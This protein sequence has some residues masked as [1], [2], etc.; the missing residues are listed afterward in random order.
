MGLGQTR[1]R[2]THDHER[3][4][5]RTLRTRLDPAAGTELFRELAAGLGL[6]ELREHVW[7]E[8]P[9]RPAVLV[10]AG[11]TVGPGVYLALWER[12]VGSE[13]DLVAASWAYADLP[14]ALAQ[15]W[16]ERDVSVA[17]QG[18]V[19]W[20]EELNL[21]PNRRRLSERAE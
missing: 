4:P 21:L 9:D 12:E 13:V 15:R 6:T 7:P 20:I 17:G 5:G 14:V 10:S 2:A 1:R 19:R 11:D 8:L 16:L 18:Q 3:V